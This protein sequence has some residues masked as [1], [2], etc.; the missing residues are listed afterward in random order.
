MVMVG[1]V[2]SRS[3]RDKVAGY[4]EGTGAGSVKAAVE[5]HLPTAYDS[6]RVI[7]CEFSVITVASVDYLAG[8][9]SIDIIGRGAA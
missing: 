2:D 4:A 8:T 5:S 3:A 1:K 7:R 9:F 6:A